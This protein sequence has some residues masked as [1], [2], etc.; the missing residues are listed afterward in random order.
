[1]RKGAFV[2]TLGLVT[3]LFVPTTQAAAPAAP[4]GVTT[5]SVS[6][7]NAAQNQAQVEVAW[8]RAVAGALG[9][10]VTA[11]AAGQTTVSKT[12]TPGTLTSTILEGLSG[13][14]SYSFTVAAKNVDGETAAPAVT[15]VPRTVA[16][17]PTVAAPVVAKGQ[18]TLSW[19]APTNTGGVELTGYSITA[20]GVAPETP[21]ASATTALITGLTNGGKYDF[22]IRA[23]NSI[24]SSTATSFATVTVPD[25]PGIPTLLTA[26]V[27]SS[28]IST[29]WVAPVDNGGSAITSYI[30]NLFDSN[31]S[32]ITAQRKTV[33]SAAANFT[34]L[35][36]GTYSVKVSAVNLVGESDKTA[37]TSPQV[38][39]ATSALTANEPV[40]SPATINDLLIDSTVT[41]TATAPSGGAVTV[42]VSPSSVCTLV[43]STGVVTGVSAGTCS[44]T[45]SIGQSGNFE[46][47]ASSKNFNVVKVA[48]SINF[49]TISP[50]TMPGPVTVSATS[51]SGTSVVL[52]AS[53][54]CTISGS[55]VTFTSAGSCTVTANASATTKYLAASTVTNTF[56]IAAAPV[57]PSG[58]GGGGGGFPVPSAPTPVVVVIIPTPT[59][60][61]TPS[62]TPTPSPSASATPTPTPS[63][64]ASATPTPTPS[65]SPSPSVTASPKPSPSPSGV[66]LKPNTF[67][68]L[69]TSKTPTTRLTLKTTS[70]S[71]TVTAGKA[72]AVTLPSIAKGVTVVTSLKMPNGKTVQVS[73]IKT[74]KSGQ[75][76]VPSLLLKK[77]GTYTLQIKFGKTVKSVKITVRK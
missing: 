32:E 50:Q 49:P 74:K 26:S 8:E 69:A 1:M 70:K 11:T 41:V 12:I 63:P 57:P 7:A 22:T 48:Q 5:T 47:G 2:L 71:L 64:S 76:T 52:A 59:P 72:L 3:A 67:V 27:S 36:A 31:G 10:V 24:G 40:I 33:T 13:G 54:N 29:T 4:S 58:G 51:S 75:F 66:T 62:P 43:T 46:A 25:R 42:T 34:G 65:P 73:S 28:T 37:A 14:V 9:Y 21:T 53:G 19:T 45:A 35:A 61:P 68:S 15:F 60:S 6:L 39:A 30:A 17:S 77:A 55:T 18:V 23:L 20:S 38:V 56:T 16:G 44:I